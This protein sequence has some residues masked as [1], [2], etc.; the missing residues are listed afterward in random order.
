VGW[1]GYSYDGFLLS[2][3][4]VVSKWVLLGSGSVTVRL[5]DAIDASS[6]RRRVR[7]LFIRLVK[8]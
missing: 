4:C 8:A 2:L 7:Y 3:G 1:C 6:L 5:C